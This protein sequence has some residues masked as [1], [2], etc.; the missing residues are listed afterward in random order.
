M[1]NYKDQIKVIGF[2]LD[3]TLYPKSPDIDTA[4]QVY[5]YHKIADHLHVSLSEAKKLFKD[6]YREGRGL[7]GSQTLLALNI[8]NSKNSIQEALEKADIIKFLKP[9]KTI[10]QL[11][12]DLKNKY[13][14]IDILTGSNLSITLSKLKHLEIDPSLFTYIITA[15]DSSKSNSDAYKD[16]LLKYPEFKPEDFLYIGDRPKTDHFIPKQLGIETILVN[17]KET[18]SEV[19][20]LQLSSLLEIKNLLI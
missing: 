13:N 7:S 10:N 14:N 4:I 19:D 12:K 17:Q 18:N 15:D 1:I 11:L 8:P 3:Q 20:C 9:N 6:L 2:D 16:W 5:L